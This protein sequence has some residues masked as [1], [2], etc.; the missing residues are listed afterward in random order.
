MNNVENE[1]DKESRLTERVRRISSAAISVVTVVLVVFVGYIM[2]C[3]ARGKA[4]EVCG[5]C[6]LKVVTGSME[7]SL[8]VGD[9]I[10]VKKADADSLSEGDIISFYSEDPDVYGKIVTHRIKQIQPDGTYITQGDANSV[11]DSKPVRYDQIIGKYQ[12]KARFYRWVG[13]F[14]DRKKLLLILVIIPMTLIALYE[15]KTI[16]KL[17]IE[18]KREK[19]LSAEDKEKLIREAIDREKAR[20]EREGFVQ[21]DPAP[22]ENG[23]AETENT[24]EEEKTAE[25]NEPDEEEKS[26]EAEAPDDVESE[27][28]GE[29]SGD[30]ENSDGEETQD[31]SKLKLPEKEVDEV[32]SG[33]DNEG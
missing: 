29:S 32:E 2:M 33:K 25:E 3:S 8:H 18:V 24:A 10:Y 15:V 20:L 5:R 16:A 22:D 13:S 30:A 28:E 23:S 21:E 6:I 31:D 9:F 1:A 17:G 14:A 7:P 4:V 11:Q 19:E 12:G 26:D 27:A